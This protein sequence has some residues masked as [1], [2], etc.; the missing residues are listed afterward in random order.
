MEQ[1]PLTLDYPP[2][3]P[4]PPQSSE[5][6]ATVINSET[7]RIFHHLHVVCLALKLGA[8]TRFAVLIIYRRYLCHYRGPH[9][10]VE[11]QEAGGFLA[12]RRRVRR[13]LSLAGLAS[14][15]LGCKTEEEPR[16]I[17][18][19]MNACAAVGLDDECT[20]DGSEYDGPTVVAS[21]GDGLRLDAEYW[22]RK[23]RIVAAE[24]ALLRALRFD[25]EVIYNILMRFM[26]VRMSR[27]NFHHKCHDPNR[28][29]PGVPASP[30]GSGGSGDFRRRPRRWI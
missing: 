5:I 24:Q 10:A 23:G 11:S 21:K 20:D 28:R 3:P 30:W 27:D 6:L 26:P 9:K 16:R 17:R 19:V 18:D 7:R 4:L 2:P 15:F 25:G 8:V 14:I 13:H 12:L 1:P 29:S 22:E